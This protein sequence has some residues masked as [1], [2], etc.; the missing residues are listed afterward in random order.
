MSYVFFRFSNYSQCEFALLN[1]GCVLFFCFVFIPFGVGR[2]VL[3]KK[4]NEPS[5][6]FNL[7]SRYYKFH[8]CVCMCIGLKFLCFIGFCQQTS[9]IHIHP[10]VNCIFLV[11]FLEPIFSNFYFLRE[12]SNNKNFIYYVYVKKNWIDYKLDDVLYRLLCECS[13]NSIP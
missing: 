2:A 11:I 6:H 8:K 9:H 7:L 13:P 5:Y 1:F 12:K 4:L 3:F 10:L